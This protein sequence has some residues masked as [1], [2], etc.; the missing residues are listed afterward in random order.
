[1]SYERDMGEYLAEIRQQQERDA[2]CRELEEARL[3]FPDRTTT[4]T[5]TLS[6]AAA[7]LADLDSKTTR[8]R[9]Q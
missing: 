8:R 1:M 6:R 4:E 9:S 2:V 5:T 3:R 7:M